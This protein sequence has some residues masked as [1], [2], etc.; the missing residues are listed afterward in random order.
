[1]QQREET[2]KLVILLQIKR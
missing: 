2:Y 1:M